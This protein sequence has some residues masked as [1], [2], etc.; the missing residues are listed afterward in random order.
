MTET[1]TERTNTILASID[2]SG[3]ERVSEDV[4]KQGVENERQAIAI[5]K[6]EGFD[7]GPEFSIIAKFIRDNRLSQDAAGKIGLEVA[8]KLYAEGPMI[9]ADTA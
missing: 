3:F 4:A 5:L 2:I 9:S 8:V 1:I 6:N 7:V